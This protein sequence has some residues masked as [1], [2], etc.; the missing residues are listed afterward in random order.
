MKAFFSRLPDSDKESTL[1]WTELVAA[2]GGDQKAAAEAFFRQSGASKW[3]F[4]RGFALGEF[5]LLEN[6]VVIMDIRTSSWCSF[7]LSFE[8]AE[9]R[10]CFRPDMDRELSEL[11]NET[12]LRPSG[13]K[14]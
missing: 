10:L 13:T 5:P 11:L 6:P 7:R 2:A 12:G 9:A 1:L 3:I 8:E 4:W 14:V